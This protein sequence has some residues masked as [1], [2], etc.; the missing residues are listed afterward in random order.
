MENRN[1]AGRGSKDEQ[2]DL[3][4]RGL[5][6]F[7]FVFFWVIVACGRH[8]SI[9]HS[10]RDVQRTYFF[11]KLHCFIAKKSVLGQINGIIFRELMELHTRISGHGPG[12]IDTLLVISSSRTGKDKIILLNRAE[13]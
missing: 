12:K 7:G 10:L 9:I 6:G 1:Y 11:L 3:P 4:G 8:D 2:D 13:E 5:D